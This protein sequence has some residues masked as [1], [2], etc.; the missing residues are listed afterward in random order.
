[1]HMSTYYSKSFNAYFVLQ[2]EFNCQWLYGLSIFMFCKQ[3]NKY[4]SFHSGNFDNYNDQ[5]W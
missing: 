1:M 4:I 2:W 5:Q 3:F